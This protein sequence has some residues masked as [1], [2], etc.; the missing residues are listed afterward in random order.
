M[1]E[2]RNK[3]I[4]DYPENKQKCCHSLSVRG[5]DAAA[6]DLLHGIISDRK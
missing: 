1:N 6:D 2:P 4:T 3:P 5:Y